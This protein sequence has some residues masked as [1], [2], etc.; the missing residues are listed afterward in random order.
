MKR[1]LVFAYDSYEA[2]GGW[3]DLDDAYDTLE[4]AKAAAEKLVRRNPMPLRMRRYDNADVVD[5]QT[6]TI[7]L[8]LSNDNS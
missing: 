3:R 7:V 8:E 4:E 2:C 1:F 6:G 5:S